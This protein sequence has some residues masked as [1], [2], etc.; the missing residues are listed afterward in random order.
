MS[1]VELLIA[2]AKD[3]TEWIVFGGKEHERSELS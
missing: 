2:E 3:E 1:K